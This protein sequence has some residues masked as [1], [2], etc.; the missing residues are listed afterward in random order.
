MLRFLGLPFIFFIRVAAELSN[1]LLGV[2]R[3]VIAILQ[4]WVI[5]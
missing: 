3:S 2:A 4:A 5:A 1:K